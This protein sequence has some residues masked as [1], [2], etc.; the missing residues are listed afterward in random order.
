MAVSL[1]IYDKTE[2][3]VDLFA[4]PDGKDVCHAGQ[5][6]ECLLLHQDVELQAVVLQRSE[7]LRS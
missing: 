5:S 3:H 6:V 7:M 4:I 2:S 1:R